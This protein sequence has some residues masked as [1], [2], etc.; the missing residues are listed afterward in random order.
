MGV[1]VLIV[2]LGWPTPTE[3]MEFCRPALG[4]PSFAAARKTQNDQKF[5]FE[6]SDNN[7]IPAAN[8][9]EAKPENTTGRSKNKDQKIRGGVDCVVSD[10]VFNPWLI[11]TKA[12]ICANISIIKV[13]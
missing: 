12:K 2:G 8:Q 10:H 4:E 3:D 6:H 9:Q 7:Y 13:R 5:R 11:T 1:E